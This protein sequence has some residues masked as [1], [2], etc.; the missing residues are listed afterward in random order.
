MATTLEEIRKRPQ[1]AKQE[2]NIDVLCQIGPANGQSESDILSPGRFRPG[3]PR[4]SIAHLL[5][6]FLFGLGGVGY[7]SLRYPR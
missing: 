4:N 3:P 5:G 7:H 2:Q 6:Y 1:H